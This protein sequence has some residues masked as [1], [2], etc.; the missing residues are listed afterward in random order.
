MLF[1]K[2]SAREKLV[3]T[4][5]SLARHNP[6]FEFIFK[7]HPKE[8]HEIDLI[9]KEFIGYENIQISRTNNLVNVLQKSTFVICIDSTSIFEALAEYKPVFLLPDSSNNFFTNLI[10]K[11]Y[12]KFYI[13]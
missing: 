13:I 9:D 11:K 12:E 7:L 5:K 2:K 6:S 4:T 10:E 1:P 8:F 3:A